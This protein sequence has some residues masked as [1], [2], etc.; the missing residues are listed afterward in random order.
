MQSFLMMSFWEMLM[1]IH[2]EKSALFSKHK[3]GK[4]STNETLLQLFAWA[5]GR[6]AFGGNVLWPPSNTH[7]AF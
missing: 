5:Q 7:S 4:N 6:C 1:L 3:P 2:V